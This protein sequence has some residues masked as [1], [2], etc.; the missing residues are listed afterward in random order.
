MVQVLC[1]VGCGVISPDER[2][3]AQDGMEAVPHVSMDC[4]FLGEKES[5]GQVTLVL[6]IREE[7]QNDAG[8]AGS[9]KRNGE[10]RSSSTSLGTTQSQSDVTLNQQLSRWQGISH[11]LVNKEVRLCQRDHQWGPTESTNAR[12]DLWLV[13]PER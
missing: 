2:S 9:K 4:G 13:R 6:V 7:T 10:Q 1:V 8:D 11:K 12:W 5:E 3:Q